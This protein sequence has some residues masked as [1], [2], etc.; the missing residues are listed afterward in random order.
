MI[1]REKCN[2]KAPACAKKPVPWGRNILQVQQHIGPE[3]VAAR[4]H[5]QIAVIP[6]HG[7]FDGNKADALSVMLGGVQ[8]AALLFQHAI[9]AVLHH[10]AHHGRAEHPGQHLD[11]PF[12]RRQLLAGMERIFQQ[13]AKN[14]AQVGLRQGQELG[15]FQLPFDLDALF[16]GLVVVVAGK[17][18]HRSVDAQGGS[19]IAEFALVLAQVA[20]QFIQPPGL[21]Q[22]G[23]HMQVLAEIVPQVAGLFQIAAQLHI[24][25][26]LHGQQLVFAVQLGAAG[27]LLCHA[28]HLV[29]QQ[30]DAQQRDA[31][32]QHRDDA[33]AV[34]QDDA[35]LLR[36]T[37]STSR[38]TSTLL[39]TSRGSDTSACKT[40]GHRTSIF[41]NNETAR[42]GGCRPCA[43][44]I[45]LLTDFFR[46]LQEIK[47]KSTILQTKYSA[48]LV[49]NTGIEPVTSCMPCKRSPEPCGY[50][51]HTK[52]WGWMAIHVKTMDFRRKWQ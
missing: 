22:A 16:P 19:G 20:F 36:H 35:D 13:V 33:D 23:D 32:C 9:V 38:S 39:R 10:Q 29:Q 27:I 51:P 37:R 11:L 18:I 7:S 1:S 5:R 12:F 49:E 24:A 8:N 43:C 45:R 44:K 2:Q 6:V 17:R 28:V 14:G 31:H 4:F 26:G 47:K 50:T 42:I 30:K 40:V 48:F 41:K 34:H 15:Q 3:N 52:L 21:G 25:A 46:S